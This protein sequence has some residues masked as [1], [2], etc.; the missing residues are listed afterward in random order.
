MRFR[1][2]VDMCLYGVIAIVLTNC[3]GRSVSSQTNGG[4]SSG[5]SACD[6][7][8]DAAPDPTGVNGQ[9]VLH[10]PDDIDPC[11]VSGYIVGHMDDLKIEM[12]IDG[13][14]FINNVPLGENDVLMVAGTLQIPTTLTG[15]PEVD[16]GIRINDIRASSGLRQQLGEVNLP[17]LGTISGK[18]T[19]ASGSVSDH[20]G[21]LVYIP[22]TSYSAYSD[23]DGSFSMTGVPAG[24]HS[25]YFEKDGFARGRIESFAVD[26]DVTS[27]AQSVQL[28]LDTGITGNFSIINSFLVNGK[29]II[30]GTTANLLMAPSAEAVTMLVGDGGMSA[31]M[32]RPVTTN[33]NFDF[34]SVNI[35]NFLTQTVGTTTVISSPFQAT[36]TA[37]FANANGLESDVILKRPYIDFFAAGSSLFAPQFNASYSENLRQIDVTGI[38]SPA[39]A[40]QMR[41]FHNSQLDPSP[42]PIPAFESL[43]S[44]KSFAVKRAIGSCGQHK[45]NIQYRGYGGK[46]LSPLEDSISAVATNHAK[47]INV[48]C[49]TSVTGTTA[50]S[51]PPPPTGGEGVTTSYYDG[52]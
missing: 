40:E 7:A 16:R 52:L 2:K 27:T 13:S 42:S 32:W 28:Y 11:S 1:R 47:L 29:T 48:P 43:A 30:P 22:G 24:L 45:I 8:L 19:L 50:I 34:T 25:L 18:V 51:Q 33:Y 38:V 17:K 3:A 39:A 35:L 12:T 23:T 31:A 49:A 44:T 14:Y 41:I 5:P 21:I 36:L 4:G 10:I 15:T 37:K 9:M 26:S 46:V 20:A 6:G